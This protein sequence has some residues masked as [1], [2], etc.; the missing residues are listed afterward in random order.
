MLIREAIEAFEGHGILS[1]KSAQEIC[2]TLEQYL[3]STGK[4]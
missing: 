3:S 1:V 2:E 4:L